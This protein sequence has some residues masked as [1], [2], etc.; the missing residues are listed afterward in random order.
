MPTVVIF[1]DHV[2]PKD[3]VLIFEGPLQTRSS[4]KS[5][6]GISEITID[7]ELTEGFIDKMCSTVKSL[8]SSEIIVESNV[9]IEFHEGKQKRSK[10]WKFKWEKK[11]QNAV[12]IFCDQPQGSADV[13]N[14]V[15]KYV[16]THLSS[17]SGAQIKTAIK[18]FLESKKITLAVKGETIEAKFDSFSKILNE[19]LAVIDGLIRPLISDR[20]NYLF[21]SLLSCSE[22]GMG[23]VTRDLGSMIVKYATHD[24]RNLIKQQCTDKSIFY[25]QY[26]PGELWDGIGDASKLVISL[27]LKSCGL[28]MPASLRHHIPSLLAQERCRELNVPYGSHSFPDTVKDGWEYGVEDSASSLK[29]IIDLAVAAWFECS[30]S[31]IQPRSLLSESWIS[32]PYSAAVASILLSPDAQHYVHGYW[33]GGWKDPQGMAAAARLALEQLAIRAQQPDVP[34]DAYLW[35]DRFRAIAGNQEREAIGKL[36]PV[37]AIAAFENVITPEKVCSIIVSSARFDPVGSVVKTCLNLRREYGYALMGRETLLQFLADAVLNACDRCD[38]HLSDKRACIRGMCRPEIFAT[39]ISAGSANAIES[40]RVEAL[41]LLQHASPI[42]FVERLV[43]KSKL[44]EES[45]VEYLLSEV[46]WDWC[47]DSNAPPATVC[48]A[49]LIACNWL[50]RGG[51]VEIIQ[52]S[53]YFSTDMADRLPHRPMTTSA[54]NGLLFEMILAYVTKCRD[55]DSEILKRQEDPVIAAFKRHIQWSRMIIETSRERDAVQALAKKLNMARQTIPVSFLRFVASNCSTEMISEGFRDV[56]GVYMDTLF[57]GSNPASLNLEQFLPATDMA[58][59]KS[60]AMGLLEKWM[61]RTIRK[62]KESAAAVQMQARLE[63]LRGKLSAATLPTFPA[64]VGAGAEDDQE[65]GRAVEV[66]MSDAHSSYLFENYARELLGASIQQAG[67]ETRDPLSVPSAAL[68]KS[69][70][71]LKG[72][73]AGSLEHEKVRMQ[74][75]LMGNHEFEREVKALCTLLGRERSVSDRNIGDDD[76]LRVYLRL[77]QVDPSSLLRWTSELRAYLV[78]DVRLS[79]DAVSAIDAYLAV[80]NRD[81]R[82]LKLFSEPVDP[83][84]ESL[85][86]GFDPDVWP[87]TLSVHH[88]VYFFETQILGGIDQVAWPQ[89]EDLRQTCPLLDTVRS[90]L[91][92]LQ[93]LKLKMDSLRV[94][95]ISSRQLAKPVDALDGLAFHLFQLVHCNRSEKKDALRLIG[96]ILKSGALKKAASDSISVADLGNLFLYVDGS[97]NIAKRNAH[98]LSTAKIVVDLDLV[99]QFADDCFNSVVVLDAISI[100]IIQTNPYPFQLAGGRT[101]RKISGQDIEALFVETSIQLTVQGNGSSDPHLKEMIE[102]TRIRYQ[103]VVELAERRYRLARLGWK[104]PQEL[105]ILEFPCKAPEVVRSVWDQTSR[106]HGPSFDIEEQLRSLSRAD[107]VTE[108]YRTVRNKYPFISF[109]P[110]LYVMKKIDSPW[111]KLIVQIASQT[112]GYEQAIRSLDLSGYNDIELWLHQ[113]LSSASQKSRSILKNITYEADGNLTLRFAVIGCSSLCGQ[114]EDLMGRS[115]GLLRVL[116]DPSSKATALFPCDSSAGENAISELAWRLTRA[117]ELVEDDSV[118]GEM[119]VEQLFLGKGIIVLRPDRLIGPLQDMLL[120]AIS[121]Y[122]KATAASQSRFPKVCL[123]LPLPAQN[124]FG[125]LL[126]TM[127]DVQILSEFELQKLDTIGR[128]ASIKTDLVSVIMTRLED[129]ALGFRPLPNLVPDTAFRIRIGLDTTIAGL[130]VALKSPQAQERPIALDFGS[131]ASKICR[132]PICGAL[133]SLIL[134]GVIGQAQFDAEVVLK[135]VFLEFEAASRDDAI[136]K[137]PMLSVLKPDRFKVSKWPRTDDSAHFRKVPEPFQ[138]LAEKIRKCACRIEDCDVVKAIRSVFGVSDE[139]KMKMRHTTPFVH[140]AQS[141]EIMGLVAFRTCVQLKD[142][143]D[144][145]RGSL[146]VI[147]S[148]DTGTGKTYLLFKFLELLRSSGAVPFLGESVNIYTISAGFQERQVNRLGRKMREL[149]RVAHTKSSKAVCA[150]ILDEMTGSSAQEAFARLVLHK[151]ISNG[152]SSQV[153]LPLSAFVLVATCNPDPDR[154]SVFPLARDSQVACIEVLPLKTEESRAFIISQLESTSRCP[155]LDGSQLENAFNLIQTSQSC[156]KE[157]ASPIGTISLRDAVRCAAL[158]RRLGSPSWQETGQSF[159][160]I[161]GAPTGGWA[162]ENEKALALAA[163]ICYGMR[164]LPRSSYFTAVQRCCSRMEH[165]IEQVKI[166]LENHFNFPSFVVKTPALRDNVLAIIIAMSARLPLLCLGCDGTSKT[167]SI[168]LVLSQM[169][170]R[171]SKSKLLQ[172]LAKAQ[173]FNLQLSE[174]STAEHIIKLKRTVTSWESKLSIPVVVMEEM[175]MADMGPCGPLRALHDLLD[176]HQEGQRDGLDENVGTGSN[177]FGFLATSNYGHRTNELPVG[178]A[179]GNRLLILAHEGLPADSLIELGVSIGMQSESNNQDTAENLRRHMRMMLLSLSTAEGRMEQLVPNEISIRSL[180]YFC[181]A[182]AMALSDT[183]SLPPDL[184]SKSFVQD[185]Q[186]RSFAAHLQRVTSEKNEALWKRMGRAFGWEMESIIRPSIK[187]IVDDS[188]GQCRTRRPLLFV[189]KNPADVYKVV[190]I[191]TK[192]YRNTCRSLPDFD[193]STELKKLCPSVRKLVL[194]RCSH[195]GRVAEGGEALHTLIQLRSAVEKGGLITILNPEPIIEGIHALLNDSGAEHSTLQLRQSHENVRIHKATQIVLLVE[196]RAAL[197]L[198]K[199]LLSRVAVMNSENF[200]W[201]DSD[202]LSP[203]RHEGAHSELLRFYGSMPSELTETWLQTEIGLLDRCQHAFDELIEILHPGQPPP[204]SSSD[205][206]RLII[207][208]IRGRIP[209]A[210]SQD[211][212][213]RF[214]DVIKYDTPSLFYGTVKSTIEKLESEGSADRPMLMLDLTA[215]SSLA[216]VECLVML[217]LAGVRFSSAT[218]PDGLGARLMKLAARMDRRVIIILDVALADSCQ[219]GPFRAWEQMPGEPKPPKVSDLVSIVE[220][221]ESTRSYPDWPLLHELVVDPRILWKRALEAARDEIACAV[222]GESEERVEQTLR[223]EIAEIALRYCAPESQT[224]AALCPSPKAD[225]GESELSNA[226]LQQARVRHCQDLLKSLLNAEQK[227]A[228][229]S[230]RTAIIESC[231]QLCHRA[232]AMLL[233]KVPHNFITCPSPEMILFV[234]RILAN[235]T[236]YW[237]SQVWS[238]NSLGLAEH[239]LYAHISTIPQVT[240]Q[241]ASGAGFPFLR[242]ILEV[243]AI[244]IKDD[245]RIMDSPV[246]LKTALLRAFPTLQSNLQ[247][248][249]LGPIF[250]RALVQNLVQHLGAQRTGE[251]VDTAVSWLIGA[252]EG[253]LHGMLHSYHSTQAWLAV[254]TYL[255]PAETGCQSESDHIKSL[256]DFALGAVHTSIDT[257]LQPR[258]CQR[259]HAELGLPFTGAVH[260]ALATCFHGQATAQGKVVARIRR[261]LLL[262]ALQLQTTSRVTVPSSISNASEEKLRIAVA[263]IDGKDQVAAL[264]DPPPDKEKA[265]L[266]RCALEECAAIAPLPTRT[267]AAVTAPLGVFH[268]RALLAKSCISRKNDVAAVQHLFDYL[269]ATLESSRPPCSAGQLVETKIAAATLREICEQRGISPISAAEFAFLIQPVQTATIAWEAMCLALGAFILSANEFL[270]RLLAWCSDESRSS[271]DEFHLLATF[272]FDQNSVCA[273]AEPLQ[274]FLVRCL[275]ARLDES[276]LGRLAGRLPRV[277]GDWVTPF[278]TPVVEGAMSGLVI[279][280]GFETALEGQSLDEGW[281]LALEATLSLTSKKEVTAAW[282]QRLVTAVE[283]DAL[284]F[285]R[286]PAAA[287]CF[288]LRISAPLSVLSS[289]G[290]LNEVG[291]GQLYMPASPEGSIAMLR[292]LAPQLGITSVNRCSCGHIYGIGECGQPMQARACPECGKLIGGTHHQWAHGMN[293]GVANG[294]DTVRGLPITWFCDGEGYTE[295]DLRPLEYRVLAVLLLLPLAVFS[296]QARARQVQLRRHWE[297]MRKVAGLSSD[298]D[299][300]HFLMGI[301]ARCIIG[302]AQGTFSGLA[303]AGFSF[304]TEA[305]RAPAEREFAARFRVVMGGS[306]PRDIV[307]NV[308]DSLSRS[309]AVKPVAA[310]RDARIAQLEPAEAARRFAPAVLCPCTSGGGS[311]AGLDSV[312]FRI[313]ALCEEVAAAPENFPLLARSLFDVE[314]EFVTPLLATFAEASGKSA[315]LP[316]LVAGFQLIHRHA[317]RLAERGFGEA[318]M[319]EVADTVLAAAAEAGGFADSKT[320]RRFRDAW[321]ICRYGQRVECQDVPDL[322]ELGALT[323]EDL[324]IGANP[325]GRQELSRAETLLGSLVAAHNAGILA[326]TENAVGSVDVGN[327]PYIPPLSAP[328]DAKSVWESGATDQLR[329]IMVPWLKVRQWAEDVLVRALPPGHCCAATAERLGR[330]WL[331]QT[332]DGPPTQLTMDGWPR[333]N[334]FGLAGSAGLVRVTAAGQVESIPSDAREALDEWVLRSGLLRDRVTYALEVVQRVAAHVERAGRTVSPETPVAD[335]V[336]D[337]LSARSII[338]PSAAERT[339]RTGPGDDTENIPSPLK[340]MLMA[341]PGRPQMRVRHLNAL[342]AE[343]ASRIHAR[344][345]NDLAAVYRAELPTSAFSSELD[346]AAEAAEAAADENRFS[347]TSHGPKGRNTSEWQRKLVALRLRLQLLAEMI[348]RDGCSPLNEM[349]PY[350]ESIVD[351]ETDGY[352][353]DGWAAM[354]EGLRLEHTFHALS[355][356]RQALVTLAAG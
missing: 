184:Q 27:A 186:V 175:S 102:T 168:N 268:G 118:P 122:S 134:C 101:E 247:L 140:T 12:A 48:L 153:K 44:H 347:K 88:M 164:V 158:A 180:L 172:A 301:L 325:A 80:Y 339:A 311:A 23:L 322:G 353:E 33:V 253:T 224:S 19:D 150:F 276:G 124:R 109:C 221:R 243:V 242:D 65:L 128:T 76:P 248:R 213:I 356:V 266:I 137:F 258:R 171:F 35:M 52:A 145:S 233:H 300:Q 110:S 126:K 199:A 125:E 16:H 77:V 115:L 316:D 161:L 25:Y 230:L 252:S 216:A 29:D 119:L 92:N 281:P 41:A 234:R 13:A 10:T 146:P 96:E 202:S 296:Q 85:A 84:A 46:N 223:T 331:G 250:A 209:V 338:L 321:Q 1:F 112:T 141:L 66:F 218:C 15:R 272:F 78:S 108:K 169:H 310:L 39:A 32:G 31:G 288:A 4:P 205:S 123:L 286:L 89:I 323:L 22:I 138:L 344:P 79:V 62:E 176:S 68:A 63:A 317:A 57:R 60:Q 292:R 239:A 73:F 324:I 6:G 190:S 227:S 340:Q 195:A 83:C 69:R 107:N 7:V 42:L 249:S 241:R 308:Q 320:V 337:L 55:V 228:F 17:T 20:A 256:E 263:V 90:K 149:I 93:D 336:R 170:G 262:T 82:Q 163:Y 120:S 165:F 11:C 3:S 34:T 210:I 236:F 279:L 349:G 51:P 211:A 114:K 21:R 131:E 255:R 157:S 203:C 189:Y 143:A 187:C 319:A 200:R 330:L 147:L 285:C 5:V 28:K 222:G 354:C 30:R 287:W 192:S 178:R 70:D 294:D 293:Q 304:T 307:A 226:I 139:Q 265:L 154:D 49:F 191:T 348:L 328:V 144:S 254:A 274:N 75:K 238:A 179:L 275:V 162:V 135:P 26:I 343:L 98:L 270:E 183:T 312:E 127:P 351:D 327:R 193:D 142:G 298:T 201:T 342:Q 71:A 56:L 235:R 148:G 259:W 58:Q 333:L 208:L 67:R 181:R 111:M 99:Q 174:Q 9:K 271:S 8:V 329:R 166:A 204:S 225:V 59:K 40:E 217:G 318:G 50:Q 277:V 121:R 245:V 116:G 299:A 334:I 104:P 129:T 269:C 95:C 257:S 326:L 306:S 220:V 54:M 332:L 43:W 64:C 117:S 264:V 155:G 91:R 36:G 24:I 133:I 240:R 2:L 185:A 273:A 309:E 251:H 302:E 105:K 352:A 196:H 103:K 81:T 182:L 53:S 177:S 355:R 278:L 74:C 215:A 232:V 335:L 314:G 214:I 14:I 346:A 341:R 113:R 295:R 305:E 207:A 246:S 94:M 47:A 18:L 280:P 197:G 97:A 38:W 267:L 260:R 315:H 194:Q 160:E 198:H 86:A 283:D 106:C 61:E 284:A 100:E 291:L 206:Q 72:A 173:A 297:M 229:L 167:L 290:F 237:Q 136:I 152:E 350:L 156:V 289:E 37:D 261:I 303:L 282:R 313:R 345:E 132:G 151:E 45:E 159:F 87:R 219:P 212:R 244:K 231:R 130:A 188:F